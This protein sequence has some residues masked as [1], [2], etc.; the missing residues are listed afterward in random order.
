MFLEIMQDWAGWLLML[1]NFSIVLMWKSVR[2]DTKVIHAIW[3]CIFFHSTVA[4]LNAYLG[5]II[6]TEMDARSFHSAGVNVDASPRPE[7]G[8]GAPGATYGNFLGLFYL[9]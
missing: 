4:F 8:F 1:F 2:S 7:W 3:L 5:G 6:G 9:L